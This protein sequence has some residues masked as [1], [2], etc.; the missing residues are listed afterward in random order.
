MC[1]LA[2]GAAHAAVGDTGVQRAVVTEIHN[3]QDRVVPGTDATVTVQNITA[4]TDD[5]TRITLENDRVPLDV[6]DAFYATYQ[7]LPDGRVYTVKDA[8]RRGML[9]LSV[10][11]FALVTA[12]VGGWIGVRALV[13]LAVSVGLI[14]YV[15]LPQLA[16]GAPPV[17]V[18]TLF[19]AA[20]LGL[21]M[22][23]THGLNRTTLAA[24]CASM[25]TIVA[26]I[27]LGNFFVDAAHLSGFTDDV[28]TILNLSTGGTLHMEGLLLGALIIG[29]LGIIDDLAITQVLTVAELK[30]ANEGLSRRE[31]Y[32]RAMRV[33]REHL[34]AVVN[35]LVL[36]YAGA[37]LPLLLLFTLS[38]SDPGL[39][40][41]SEVMA[42]EVIRSA[43]GGV[44]LAVV[45]PVATLLGVWIVRPGE[46]E[47]H[48]RH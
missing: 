21:A 32:R 16:A 19:A 47:V 24:F 15:L 27:L 2:P 46:G 1:A 26:A 33:G 10:A 7:E 13:S 18:A 40:L 36:A 44:A 39:L 4:R 29:V 30:R 11:L 3:Q 45:L 22:T 35:T 48:H 34:G 31:L 5:G 43:V 8:D 28:T 37:S 25:L 9:L 14:V 23:V 20:L 17:L 6:G 41:N 12:A 42:V 38:P